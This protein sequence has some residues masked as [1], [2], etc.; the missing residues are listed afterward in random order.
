MAREEKGGAVRLRVGP[1]L[2]L[3][4]QRRLA[5]L[6]AEEASRHYPESWVRRSNELGRVRVGG[7]VPTLGPIC[8]VLF[9]VAIS[10]AGLVGGL[11][12]SFAVGRGI[13]LGV[14]FGLGFVW[15][16]FGRSAAG[17][18][19][20]LGGG[21]LIVG[22][23]SGGAD[24]RGAIVHELGHRMQY[25]IPGLVD[26]E[27][28]FLEEKMGRAVRVLPKPIAPLARL[29]RNIGLGFGL[30]RRSSYGF[31]HPYAAEDP[32]NGRAYEV[33]TT[34]HEAVR[35]GTSN[36]STGRFDPG[37]RPLPDHEAFVWRVMREL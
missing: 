18:Y 14:A 17:Q 11:P 35:Y 27:R 29:V 34:G 24:L 5:E 13:L 8:A 25:A 3:P 23:G 36:P 31:F 6:V 1:L 37:M 10:V 22:R 20:H 12:T 9:A 26:E 30:L 15:L 4:G 33:F 21:L 16:V 19:A 32:L 7:W 28:A 2:P